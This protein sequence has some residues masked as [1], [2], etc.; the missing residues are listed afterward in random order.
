MRE[1]EEF[2]QIEHMGPRR[3]EGLAPGNAP[4]REARM[5]E[6]DRL[7]LDQLQCG[8]G[9]ELV[10]LAFGAD[11]HRTAG[12]PRRHDGRG[13]GQIGAAGAG[14]TVGRIVGGI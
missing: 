9:F 1:G 10:D 14:S 2:H 7:A 6:D 13:I 5:D 8:L 12:R 4:R 11:G 3:A